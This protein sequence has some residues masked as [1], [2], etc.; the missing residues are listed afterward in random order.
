MNSWVQLSLVV[1]KQDQ[2]SMKTTMQK[3]LGIWF[4]LVLKVKYSNILIFK[5]IFVCQKS[6]ESLQKKSLSIQ[7]WK[8]N[9]Y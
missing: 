1:S 5:A 8:I 6:V 2:R 7:K 9:F 4:D 3:V